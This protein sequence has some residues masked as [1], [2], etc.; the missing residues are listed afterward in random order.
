MNE[1]ERSTILR[2]LSESST[3][4]EGAVSGVSA[5][6]AARKPPEDGWSVAEIVEH[7]AIGEEQMFFALTERFRPVPEAPPDEEKEMKLRHATL[8]RNRKAISPEPTRPS[9]RFASLAEALA[10]FRACRART[11]HYV[12]QGRDNLRNRSVKH[13]LAGIVTGYEYLLILANHPARHAAQI[14]GVRAAL[15]F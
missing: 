1:T 3:E 15:G 9:G 7:V 12:E 6:D 2:L 14:R 10:H 13:P 5:A 4:L 11:I 8:D